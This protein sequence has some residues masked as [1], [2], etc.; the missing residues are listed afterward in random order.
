METRNQHFLEELPK[1][2]PA[3]RFWWRWFVDNS[4]VRSRKMLKLENLSVCSQKYLPTGALSFY[5]TNSLYS[6]WIQGKNLLIVYFIKYYYY[7]GKN[8]IFDYFFVAW[9]ERESCA[10]RLRNLDSTINLFYSLKKQISDKIGLYVKKVVLIKYC[11][12]GLK[13]C[14]LLKK[15]QILSGFSFSYMNISSNEDILKDHEKL[16]NITSNNFDFLERNQNWCR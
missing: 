11:V 15:L 2:P 3:R 9:G 1:Y 8:I 14:S 4:L 12:M 13:T 10:G 16:W 5:I 6:L 7:Y